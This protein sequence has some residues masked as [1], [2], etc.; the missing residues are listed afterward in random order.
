VERYFGSIPRGAPV[1]LPDISE[2]RQTQAKFKSERDPLAPRPAFAAA[3]HVPKR[4]SP[5]WYA[6]GLLDQIL[7][8]GQDS[9]LYQKLVRERGIT[10]SVQAG[11]NIG[12]GNMYN[13]NG[14][15][16]WT[17]GFMHDPSKSH[18]DI[19]AAIE[20]VIEGVRT[21]PVS[22]EEL[23]RAQTKIRA[24]LYSIADPATRFG[25]VDLLAVGAMWE[26]DPKWAN[27]LERGFARVTPQLL[28]A[29]A[30]EYLRP[31][32][33]SILVTEAGAAAPAAAKTGASK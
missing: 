25:I 15:M 17:V 5:E 28:M 13:Y 22:Q 18:Q 29:T 19:T 26:N 9:R 31:T 27:N 6:M 32:N 33:R 16:Q 30:R 10:S 11:I 24:N 4:N 7:A 8:Q 2:P 20:E 14:P 21:K 23:R 1:R 12:L 3:W